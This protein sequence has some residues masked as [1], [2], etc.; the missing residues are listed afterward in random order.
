[1][2]AIA[3]TDIVATM[4]VFRPV[5]GMDKSEI[6]HISRKIDTYDISIEP[7]EDCCTVFTPRHP[8]TKP[9][10]S[11]IIQEQSKYDFSPL[12]ETAIAE[13]EKRTIKP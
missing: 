6:I 11:D 4:P 2:S 8:R 13:T 10:L 3:C 7:Y 5:I 12:I 9:V 1:M